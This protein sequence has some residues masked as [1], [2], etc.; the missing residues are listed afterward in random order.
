MFTDECQYSSVNINVTFSRPGLHHDAFADRAE[1]PGLQ[2]L[3]KTEH[4]LPLAVAFSPLFFRER[5]ELGRR[6]DGA[7]TA[8]RRT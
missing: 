4:P 3:E 5:D 2:V 1:S 8:T 6:Q 7:W